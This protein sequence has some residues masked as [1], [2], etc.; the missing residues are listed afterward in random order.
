MTPTIETICD[1]VGLTDRHM[2]LV[3]AAE[4]SLKQRKP[5]KLGP[6]TWVV[7]GIT[8]NERRRTVQI[9]GVQVA[10]DLLPTTTT[11]TV[12]TD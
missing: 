4:Q 12:W 1:L 9:R 8:L 10:D 11:L 5:I 2:E 6:K 7:V 3:A